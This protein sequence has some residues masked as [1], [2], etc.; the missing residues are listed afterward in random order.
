LAVRT[1]QRYALVQDLLRR[2]IS[3]AGIARSLKLDP[4]TVRRFATATSIDDLL[5]NT[6][7]RD[8]IIDPFRAH[9]HQRWNEG[10]TDAAVLCN[11]I[12]EQGFAGSDQTVRRYVRPFR[13]SLTAPPAPP[14]T[15]KTRHVTRWIMINPANL[16]ADDQAHLDAISGR[17]P[18]IAALINHVH[19]FATMMTKRTGTRDL[20]QWIERIEASGLAGLRS[21]ATSIRRDLSAVTAGLALALQLRTGGRPRQL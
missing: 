5:V 20:P 11:E 9:L 8:S 12:R 21:F 2:G 1:R 18:A 3:R 6:G 4:H 15:P 17:S 7:R 19:A 14:S 16:D 10:C 13:A